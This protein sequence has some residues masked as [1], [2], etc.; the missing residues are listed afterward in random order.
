MKKEKDKIRYEVWR[1]L[2]ELGLARFP[3]PV[4]GRIPNFIGAEKAASRLLNL[5][6]YIDA[7]VVKVSPDSPQRFRGECLKEPQRFGEHSGMGE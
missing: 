2:E 1:K 5:R 6:E 3:R 4:Y 7:R